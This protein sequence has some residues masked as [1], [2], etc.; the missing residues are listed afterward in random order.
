MSGY[1]KAPFRL[2]LVGSN[3]LL[4]RYS[5]QMKAVGHHLKIARLTGTPSQQDCH[6]HGVGTESFF[7]QPDLDT[8]CLGRHETQNFQHL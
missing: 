2:G 6:L 5:R 4:T 8:D 7:N 1:R 3:L